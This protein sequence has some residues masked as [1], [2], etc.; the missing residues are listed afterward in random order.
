[1]SVGDSLVQA[2][3][4]GG[5]GDVEEEVED[6]DIIEDDPGEAEDELEP[7]HEGEGEGGETD[8]ELEIVQGV[9][10]DTEMHDADTTVT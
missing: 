2:A 5:E 7:E 9:D 10:E 4:E 6:E 8:G 1:M 3:D